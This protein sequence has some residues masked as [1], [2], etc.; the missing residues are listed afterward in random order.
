[1]ALME[2]LLLKGY[3]DENLEENTES[4]T[5]DYL[6]RLLTYCI[7]TEDE[8][9]PKTRDYII[10][11]IES[12]DMNDSEETWLFAQYDYGR[13]HNYNKE[14]ILDLKKSVDKLLDKKNLDF[15]ILYHLITICLINNDELNDSQAKIIGD[16]ISIFNL[17]PNICDE[18]Y[19]KVLKEKN[20]KY[21][22]DEDITLDDLDECYRILGL[23][24]TAQKKT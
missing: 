22:K 3:I 7:K 24:K 18:I 19:D 10:N 14:T 8:I 1:M 17:D 15:N 13:F 9:S 4:A 23:K 12:F 6:I 21:E 16:F 5:A 2:D 11:Y 20:K